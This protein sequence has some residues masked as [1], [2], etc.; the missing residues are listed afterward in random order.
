[1]KIAKDTV[2]TVRYKVVDTKGKL[3]EDSRNPMV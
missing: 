3:L 2:V 1:M